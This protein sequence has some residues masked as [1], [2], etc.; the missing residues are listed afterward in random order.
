MSDKFVTSSKKSGS[1]VQG[2]DRTGTN[3]LYFGEK[4]RNGKRVLT[5]NEKDD[6][7]NPR[8]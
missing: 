5:E 2:L 1:P 6:S 3:Y 8:I 4:E 7:T